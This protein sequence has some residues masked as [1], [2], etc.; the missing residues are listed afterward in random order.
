MSDYE[1]I[2][3]EDRKKLDGRRLLALIID[4][5][6]LIPV[7]FVFPLLFGEMNAGAVLIYLAAELAYF[8][9][10][11]TLTGQTFGKHVMDLRVVRASDAGPASAKAISART[12]LRLVDGVPGAYLVGLL[13]MILTGKRRQRLGDLAARTV[14]TRA[15]ARPY[16]P[17]QHSRLTFG[18]PAMWLGAA[19]AIVVSAGYGGDTGLRKLDE[20]CADYQKQMGPNP[21]PKRKFQLRAAMARELMGMRPESQRMLDAGQVLIRGTSLEIALAQ[22]GDFEGAERLAQLHHQDLVNRGL[23]NC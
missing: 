20:M 2:W 16:T 13:T 4:T 21:A 23:H 6:V 9:V 7:V 12:V 19:V 3:R 1:P 14:V 18:Y 10:T 15:S 17:G 22:T 11:E 8:H 5:I